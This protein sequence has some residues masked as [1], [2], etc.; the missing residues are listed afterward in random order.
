MPMPDKLA[1]LA[2]MAGMSGIAFGQT[3]DYRKP[4]PSRMAY[5]G[6]R[7]GKHAV[8]P[9]FAI[10]TTNVK[11]LKGAWMAAVEFGLRPGILAAGHAR[12][13][14]RRDVHH[15][16]PAGYLRARRKDRRHPSG[17]IRPEAD[18]K[19]P[20][21]KAKRGVGLGEGMVFGVLTDIRKPARQ[22]RGTVEPVTYLLALDQKN[23]KLLWKHELGEDVPE[24]LPQIHHS[25]ATLLQGPGVHEHL[26]RRWR[27]A[28][29]LD[30]AQC[31]NRRTKYGAGMRFPVQ[32]SRATRLGKAS[33]GRP[34]AEPCGCSRR[35]IP[36]WD[37]ST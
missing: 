10:N 22:Q 24:E 14:R 3:P 6:R 5:G 4:P 28:R 30:G 37:F 21:N 18:P 16:W 31:K 29:T 26:R 2:L 11:T 17:N 35:S 8:L 33:P 34:A 12:D 19:T 9:A 25:A 15:H 36:T 32:A 13:Q 1:L 27:P 7:L 23:G 20:D